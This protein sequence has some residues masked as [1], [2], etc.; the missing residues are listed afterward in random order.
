MADY[1][2]TFFGLWELSFAGKTMYTFLPTFSLISQ[3]S[4]I[5]DVINGEI[6][7]LNMKI[8]KIKQNIKF[9]AKYR[10]YWLK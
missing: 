4:E 6:F 3:L 5:D 1:I 8:S 7:R 9:V 2:I 10:Q